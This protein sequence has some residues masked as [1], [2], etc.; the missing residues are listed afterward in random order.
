VLQKP[1]ISLDQQLT[2]FTTSRTDTDINMSHVTKSFDHPRSSESSYSTCSQLSSPGYEIGSPPLDLSTYARTMHQHAKK[3]MDAA[4]QSARQRSPIH[5][6]SDVRARLA[7]EDS[8]SS[9]ESNGSL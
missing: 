6:G 5:T 7:T 9:M 4:L 3:Q 8:V 2:L 1:T